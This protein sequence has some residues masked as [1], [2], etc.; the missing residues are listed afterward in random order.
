[1]H[2]G[3]REHVAQRGRAQTALLGWRRWRGAAKRPRQDQA[4]VI[5]DISLDRTGGRLSHDG[6]HVILTPCEFRVLACLAR[7]PG[8]TVS[9]SNVQHHLARY[10]GSRTT[11][12][13]DVYILYLRR[14][15][16]SL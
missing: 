8:R 5:N 1:M 15:L 16:A 10:S 14:K 6:T 7:W 4:S 9:R 12:L 13:V 2:R 11:N 3:H